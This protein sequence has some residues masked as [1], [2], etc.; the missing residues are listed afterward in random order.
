MSKGGHRV[1]SA[2]ENC[3]VF[4]DTTTMSFQGEG[5]KGL[6]EYGYCRDRRPDLRQI[7]V[8]VAITKG[9]VHRPRGL[10]WVHL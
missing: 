6:A 1:F 8:A 4:F 9:G 10:P 5:L 7:V 2:N 3:S